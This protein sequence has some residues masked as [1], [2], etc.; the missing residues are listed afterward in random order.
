MNESTS[1]NWNLIAARTLLKTNDAAVFAHNFQGAVELA[2]MVIGHLEDEEIFEDDV[3]HGISDW[4]LAKR[5]RIGNAR[6][7]VW[8]KGKIC[9]SV[10]YPCV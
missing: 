1:R 7:N 9:R 6:E 2:V 10:S 4:L 3:I 8:R 5:E